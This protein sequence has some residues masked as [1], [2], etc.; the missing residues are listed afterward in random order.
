MA[1][2]LSYSNPWFVSRSARQHRSQPLLETGMQ[3]AEPRL[4]SA[5]YDAFTIKAIMGQFFLRG[6]WAANQE[7][8]TN[9]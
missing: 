4:V 7:T 5:G 3:R 6:Y 8:E 1:I 9:D 2:L